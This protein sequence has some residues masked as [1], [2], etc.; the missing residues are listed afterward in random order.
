MADDDF[1][2]DAWLARIAYTGPRTPDLATLAGLIAAQS[3]AI[4]FENV[5]VLLGRVPSLGLADLQS[6]LIAGRRG[7]YCFELNSI[8]RAGLRALGFTVTG[9]IAR[10]I[11]GQEDD[12]PGPATHMT[13]R[14]DL[15]QGPYLADVG[16]GNLTP[17][18]P[19]AMV[20]LLE[21]QTP[22]ETLRL[23]PWQDEL[24]LQ[25]KF[26]TDWQ[27]VYR[28]SPR[29]AL[30]VDYE[31]ANWLTAHH[32]ASPFVGTLVIA[33]PGPDGERRTFYN[34][35]LTIR[36]PGQD[37]E[38]QMLTNPTFC[39]TTLAQTFGLTLPEADLTQALALLETAGTTGTAHPFFT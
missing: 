5:D 31:M 18:A 20:A 12:A 6:K 22:H 2:V 34:G 11:R 30:Q 17:T 15:P 25:V 26:G 35:R 38:R 13:L 9:L 33:R 37:P 4:P 32:P 14:V 7:G 36:R 19:L 23:K 3:A 28:L 39:A 1:D 16:F 29:P 24:L 10:V 21:Q 8:F 27:N